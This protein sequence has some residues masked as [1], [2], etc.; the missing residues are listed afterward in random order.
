MVYSRYWC[1]LLVRVFRFVLFSWCSLV[2]EEVWL[3]RGVVGC[4]WGILW[5]VLGIRLLLCNLERLVVYL[6]YWLCLSKGVF[7][8]VGDF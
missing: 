5:S 2:G 4:L 3:S 1:S 7:I 6:M 8:F